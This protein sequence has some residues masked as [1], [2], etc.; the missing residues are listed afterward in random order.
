MVDL[1]GGYYIYIYTPAS[2]RRTLFQPE[3][4]QPKILIFQPGQGFQPAGVFS[5]RISFVDFWGCEQVGL[6][7]MKYTQVESFYI[8]IFS[9][10][11]CLI[12]FLYV[13]GLPTRNL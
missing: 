2:L 4:V 11:K 9:V 5:A 1:W 10:L 8:T 13:C 3:A 6:T 12:E 7:L